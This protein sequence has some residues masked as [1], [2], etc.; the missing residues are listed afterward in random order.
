MKI[1]TERELN[2]IEQE[3]SQNHEKLAEG[4]FRKLTGE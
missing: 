3:Y 2:A 1:E 4:I